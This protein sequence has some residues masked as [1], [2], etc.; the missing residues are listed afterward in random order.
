MREAKQIL[1]TGISSEIGSVLA[2]ELTKDPDVRIIGTMRRKRPPS[3]NLGK[4]IYIIDQ[5]DLTSPECCNRVAETVDRR[6]RGIFGLVHSVGDFW[7]HVPFLDFGPEQA[8]QMFESHVATFYNILQAIVPVMKKKGGG[9]VIAFSCNSGR[10][11]YPWMASFTA[12]KAAVDSLVRSLANEFAG[13]GLRFNS[14]VLASVKTKKV[15]TSKPHG[16]FAHFIPPK[17]LVPVVR[18]LL[19]REAYLVNGNAI[20]L[21]K[22]SPQFYNKGYFQ[23]IA[24]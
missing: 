11:Y 10:Y 22:Y 23:R 15:R 17:D 4:H 20:N 18:F 12:S 21:F 19:S 5:C 2:K 3:F 6:F 9:S 7:N 1:L 8:K 24:K 14:I 13:D 16:D